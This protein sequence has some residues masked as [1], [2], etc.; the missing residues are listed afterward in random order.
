VSSAG[1]SK[2]LGATG[3][4]VRNRGAAARQTLVGAV[5]GPDRTRVVVLMACVLALASADTATVGASAVELRR[6]L[7]INNTDVGLLVSVTAVVAAVFSLPFGVLADRARRIWILAFALVTWGAAML[8]SA[9][10]PSFGELLLARLC[11]GA[12]TAAAGPVTASLI[13]DWFP[14][15]ERGRIYGFVLTGELLG[16]GLGFAITGDIA[17]LSWR[18]AFIILA[19]PAFA[20]AWLIFEL[21]EP[22]RGGQGVLA[23]EQASRPADGRRTDGQRPTE[24]PEPPDAQ[25]LAREQGIQPD[26]ELVSRGSAHLSF[27]EALR[28]IL[29]VRTNVVLI[30]SGACAYY[31]LAGVQTFGTEFV[32][33]Q[34]HVDQ[35]AAN[36]LLLVVG[37]GA[38]VGV[39]V[40]GPASDALLRRGHLSARVMTAA[41]AA[42]AA[43]LLFIPA[44]ITRSVIT[45]LP[46]V[47]FAAAALS[48]QNPPI[49]AA[50]L[51]IMPPWLWGRAE[52]VRTFLRTMAQALAPVL[53]GAVADYVFG[54]G[55]T[56]LR[57]TF[58]VMLVPLA[59]SAV[60]LY[61]ATRLYPADVATAAALTAEDDG[62]APG[63]EPDVR[64]RNATESATR[65]RRVPAVAAVRPARRVLLPALTPPSTTHAGQATGPNHCALSR[66]VY[67][68]SNFA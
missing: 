55:T 64:L 52:G 49:D 20:L 48:A 11:L 50:R 66:R 54:G 9:A 33:G 28:Y 12:V 2:I 6:E 58:V 4:F 44:L 26:Y 22:A 23:P 60:F 13:G 42:T 16:A 35:V 19:L 40:S 5:G 31:F 56:G 51:D 68:M 45:A 3:R 17:A 59:A 14:A 47:I 39:L 24:V 38:V 18:A 10:A 34:Y 57:W 37:A 29:A 65:G 21:P 25:R 1:S 41:V 63:T 53:F 32:S 7:H 36:L 30:I 27:M 15:A 46:Y 62:T 61:R 67:A 43:V 8:W